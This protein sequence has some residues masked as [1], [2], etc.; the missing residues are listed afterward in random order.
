MSTLIRDAPLS[1]FFGPFYPEELKVVQNAYRGVCSRINDRVLDQVSKEFKDKFYRWQ[2][3]TMDNH[4]WHRGMQFEVHGVDVA[5]LFP[6]A[7][8]TYQGERRLISVY[9]RE[10][11]GKDEL[12]FF[13][14]QFANCVMEK[15]HESGRQRLRPRRN[16]FQPHVAVAVI[17]ILICLALIVLGF[18]VPLPATPV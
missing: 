11:L 16:K 5:V 2:P 9:T 12:S 1:G 18:E 6:L 14:E 3:V 15:V 13:A 7:L 8:D 10:K 4:P 17:L